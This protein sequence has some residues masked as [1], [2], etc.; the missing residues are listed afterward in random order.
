MIYHK[1][2]IWVCVCVCLHCSGVGVEMKAH[3]NTIGLQPHHLEQN[4]LWPKRGR[5]EDLHGIERH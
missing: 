3:Y 5:R 2:K 1:C 4:R